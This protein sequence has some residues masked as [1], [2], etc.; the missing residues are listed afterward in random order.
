MWKSNKF[1]QKIKPIHQVFEFPERKK[2]NTR[3]ILSLMLPKIVI[4]TLHL[5][6]LHDQPANYA[7]CV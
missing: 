7:L 6:C 5:L 4:N 3:N 2:K 1:H